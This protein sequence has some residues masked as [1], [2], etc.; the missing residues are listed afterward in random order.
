MFTDETRIGCAFMNRRL[1]KDVEL[2]R[3]SFLLFI[4]FSILHLVLLLFQ[5]DTID[6]KIQWY[7]SVEITQGVPLYEQITRVVDGEKIWATHNLPVFFYVYASLMFIFG[8]SQI[9][10]RLLLWVSTI[11]LGLLLLLLIKPK[12]NNEVQFLLML[13]F[14]NPMLLIIN[15]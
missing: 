14:L 7:S 15:Y 10:G 1:F 8:P 13:Y 2:N 12:A 5:Y 3:Q 6:W 11:A 9:V 4:G